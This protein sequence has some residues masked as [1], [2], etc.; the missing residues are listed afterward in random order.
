ADV[1]VSP[2][3]TPPVHGA[4]IGNTRA[5]YGASWQQSSLGMFPVLFS[6][7]LNTDAVV[8]GTSVTGTVT[9]QRAAPTGGVDVTLVSADTSLVRPPLHVS[10]PEG[11]TAASFAVAT[12]SVAGATPVVIDTGT[13][14]GGDRAPQTV[15]TR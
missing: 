12:S 15:P 9:L 3:T 1:M 6:L 11:A 7:A 13:A 10:V 14:S 5:A 4:T 8:G 2:I